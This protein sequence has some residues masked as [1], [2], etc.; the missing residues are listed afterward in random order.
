MKYVNQRVLY[1]SDSKCWRKSM[2]KN[3]SSYTMGRNANWYS[4]YGDSLKN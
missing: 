1:F 3:E 2:E 4:P